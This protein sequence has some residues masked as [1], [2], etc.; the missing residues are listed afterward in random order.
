MHSKFIFKSNI[1]ISYTFKW[2]TVC[3]FFGKINKKFIE[4][5]IFFINTH[6]LHNLSVYKWKII[7]LIKKSFTVY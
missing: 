1:Y 2:L 4:L 7:S 3:I 5:I 6:E